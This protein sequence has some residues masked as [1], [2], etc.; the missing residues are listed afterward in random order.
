MK[1]KIIFIVIASQLLFSSAIAQWIDISPDTILNFKTVFF[2]DSYNGYAIGCDPVQSSWSSN[3]LFRT[4]DNGA[5]WTAP[6]SS[7]LCAPSVY[8]PNN[9]VG[10]FLTNGSATGSAGVNKTT[11]GGNTW[12]F[13]YSTLPGEHLFFVSE[14]IGFACQAN[15]VSKT[16]DGGITWVNKN[17]GVSVLDAIFFIDKDTGYI[18][19]WYVSKLAKTINGGDDWTDITTDYNIH[20]IHFPSSKV[21]YAVGENLMNIP[22]IIKTTDWGNSWSEVYTVAAPDIFFFSSISCINTNTCYAVGKYGTILKTEDGGSNWVTESSGTAA[23]L[24][25]V[26]CPNYN[27]CYVAGDSGVLLRKNIIGTS[28]SQLSF[29]TD[30]RV[31]VSPNP[32]HT[33]ITVATTVSGKLTIF[34]TDGREIQD[35]AISNTTTKLSLP[36]HLAAGPYICRFNGDDGLATTLLLV[37]ER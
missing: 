25:S 7:E 30:A 27:A 32:A 12:S 14:N 34:T 21:G 5:S 28:V 15:E 13:I 9:D 10:Y 8:F 24:H 3:W 1:N 20:A 22:V 26:H 35:Y 37:C 4:T 2:R 6:V 29:G 11:D 33:D 31:S 36:S 18:G 17:I 19:G 23:N 16:V